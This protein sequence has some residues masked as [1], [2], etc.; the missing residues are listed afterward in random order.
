MRNRMN[1]SVTYPAKS[2]P[3][4]HKSNSPKLP[5]GRNSGQKKFTEIQQ[6]YKPAA[7]SPNPTQAAPGARGLI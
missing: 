4:G 3:V 7:G 5:D 6:N 1:K 2:S